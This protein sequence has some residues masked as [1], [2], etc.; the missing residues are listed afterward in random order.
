[1]ARP[2]SIRSGLAQRRLTRPGR[3]LGLEPLERRDLLAVVGSPLPHPVAIDDLF[4]AAGAPLEVSAPGVL[5]ND[6]GPAGVP[7]SAVLLEGPGHGKLELARDGSFVYVPAPG[8][9]GIDRFS[10]RVVVPTTT[11]PPTIVPLADSTGLAS[12]GVTEVLPAGL[13]TGFGVPG[14][15]P[16]GSPGAVDPFPGDPTRPPAPVLDDVGVVTIYVRPPLPG[17][18]A[19]PDLY[20]TSQGQPLEVPAPGVLLNDKAP[21]GQTLTAALLTSPTHGQVTLHSDGS[22]VYVPAED[23]FGVDTFTYQVQAGPAP[24]LV[25]SASTAEVLSVS[26]ARLS[27]DVVDPR[28]VPNPPLPKPLPRPLD[29]ATVT[30]H[31]RPS[32]PGVVALPDRYVTPQDQP[33]T[34]PAPGV[35]AN[36]LSPLNVLLTAT[37]VDPPRH[38]VLEL[39]ADGGFRYVPAEGFVG[40]DYFRYRA[41]AGGADPGS[42][43]DSDEPVEDDGGGT[44]PS[45]GGA[46]HEPGD[47]AGDVSEDGNRP[48]PPW[49]RPLPAPDP[50]IAT[51]VI[52]VLGEKVPPVVILPRHEATDESGP[53]VVADF[54]LPT[55]VT[56]VGP[57]SL[58]PLT[59]VVDRPELFAIP[60]TVDAA[61]RLSYTP[62]P[63]ARGQAVV[64]VLAAEGGL[65]ELVGRLTITITKPRPLFNVVN[66]RDVTGDGVVSPLDALLVIN[67]LNS[68]NLPDVAVAE[69]AGGHFL[70]VSG[71]NLI[72]PIDAL[73]VINYLNS[74]NR[75]PG[76]LVGGA[77]DP[78]GEVETDASTPLGNLAA[79]SLLDDTLQ[80]LAADVATS[81][82]RR[83]K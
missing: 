30:I 16:P 66:P 39:S 65:S 10:Y 26:G 69:G 29:V 2:S 25:S 68:G 1:M 81:L 42:D 36:D 41:S 5:A 7:L 75:L 27:G 49:V 62:A 32:R 20:V 80:L 19:Q 64:E 11:P 43:P 70:D 77:T 55:E 12:R 57:W 59:L 18:I 52:L 51:V 6:R 14:V 63:N 47:T 79:G 23:F 28:E 54:A 35:L 50:S 33:L 67:Y 74:F 83:R 9:S 53:Q 76:G 61:G 31:V 78:T 34:V 82:A 21:P 46:G 72:S 44:D 60:P 38:G 15:S 48:W 71:D 4:I 22:F 3:P 56:D 40:A 17:P 13:G 45:G 58:P 73:L 37:L 24:S 8:Y